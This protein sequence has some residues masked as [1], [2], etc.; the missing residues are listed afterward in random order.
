MTRLEIPCDRCGELLD[1]ETM[2]LDLGLPLPA[3]LGLGLLGR[4]YSVCRE[5]KVG[6]DEFAVWCRANLGLETPDEDGRKAVG[7]CSDHDERHER[8]LN[9]IRWSRCS[10]GSRDGSGPCIHR[11]PIAW[12]G[13]SKIG[14]RENQRPADSNRPL[15]LRNPKPCA[16]AGEGAMLQEHA[17]AR[18]A[19]WTLKRWACE[20]RMA[21]EPKSSGAAP[22]NSFGTLLCT[23]AMMCQMSGCSIAIAW[24]RS[25][26]P[27]CTLRRKNSTRTDGGDN[28]RPTGNR[29]GGDTTFGHSF[30]IARS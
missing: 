26:Q 21:R 18:F 16:V 11:L 1:A 19:S 24:S 23:L 7:Q 3:A 14:I 6:A 8:W 30:S 29:N 9:S 2:V 22:W 4:S 10:A 17:P 5:C 12:P 13:S 28:A 15:R 27:G 20:K 25:R